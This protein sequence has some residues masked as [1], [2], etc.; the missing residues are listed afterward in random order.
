MSTSE[1]VTRQIRVSVISE[2]SPDRS[3]PQDRQWFFL[4]TITIANDSKDTIQLLSRHWVITDDSGEVEEVK[5]QGVIG[6]QPVIKPGEDLH[7]HVRRFAADRPRHH[8]GHVSD[9]RRR[10]QTVRRHDSQIYA[11]RALYGPLKGLHL[12]SSAIG[13]SAICNRKDIANRQSPSAIDNPDG[14]SIIA[15]STSMGNVQLSRTL[16][17]TPARE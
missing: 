4:Y 11:E 13:E 15:Q 3:R 17:V 12:R 9:D 8:G 7:L 5:G 6:Q 16:P 14:S 1:A 2:Y 10:R